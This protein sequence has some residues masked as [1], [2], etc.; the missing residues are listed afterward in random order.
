MY[1]G[2]SFPIGYYFEFI[3]NID[4]D[5]DID[6]DFEHACVLNLHASMVRLQCRA[7]C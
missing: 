2:P 1:L 7:V 5:I 3:M 6:I 4:I